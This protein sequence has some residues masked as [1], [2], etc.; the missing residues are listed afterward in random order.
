[1]AG[2]GD[3]QAAGPS[4]LARLT[5][6]SDRLVEAERVIDAIGDSVSGWRYIGGVAGSVV[7]RGLTCL[8]FALVGHS[9]RYLRETWLADLQSVSE[10][11]RPLTTAAKLR[12]SR[13]FVVA[14]IRLRLADAA[15]HGDRLLDA[16]LASDFRTG[17]VVAAMT[18]VPATYI[19]TSSGLAGLINN[20]EDILVTV[21]ALYGGAKWLRRIRGDRPTGGRPGPRH[22]RR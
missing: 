3:R 15:S 20:A 14:A 7:A 9:R 5:C 4:R 21:G 6:R 18:L 10:A 1:M 22:S 19:F 8:A 16:L 2:R 11:G 17:C 12:Y 13:G